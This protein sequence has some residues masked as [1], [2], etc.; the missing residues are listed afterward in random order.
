MQNFVVPQFIDAEDKILFFITVRQFVIMIVDLLFVFLLYRILTFGWFLIAGAPVL[1]AGIVVAFT[2]INGQPFHF[3]L[4]NLIATMKQPRTR[5]WN[6]DLNDADLELLM[7]KEELAQII[8][9]AAKPFVTHSKLSE[10]SLIVNTGG[11]YRGD[12]N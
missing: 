7:T 3:F 2:R 6:K 8:V 10:I 12:E 1:T 9:P 5:V 11:A 4:I